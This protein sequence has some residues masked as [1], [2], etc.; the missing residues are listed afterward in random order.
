MAGGTA[1]V[2]GVAVKGADEAEHA[3]GDVVLR[4]AE[5][6]AL[7]ALDEQAEQCGQHAAHAAIARDRQ[8]RAPQEVVQVRLHQRVGQ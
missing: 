4:A 2:A 5:R 8:R 3:V 6:A 7:E 1:V